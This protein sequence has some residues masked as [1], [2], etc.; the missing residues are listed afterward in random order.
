MARRNRSDRCRIEI[1]GL[2]RPGAPTASASGRGVA[3]A[4][5]KECMPASASLLF[6]Y[7][8]VVFLLSIMRS[9]SALQ[10]FFGRRGGDGG[11]SR[12]R[13]GAD[14]RFGFSGAALKKIRKTLDSDW[15]VDHNLVSLLQRM[16]RFFKKLNNR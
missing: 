4:G 13:C 2:S 7:L 12:G 1:G 11:G 3:R 14:Q 10:G 6:F 8:D 15:I 16:Q 5:R 9:S